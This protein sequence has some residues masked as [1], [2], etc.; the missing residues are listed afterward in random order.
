MVKVF[1]TGVTDAAAC[2]QCGVVAELRPYGKDNALICFE[3]GMKDE[4]T[5]R[6]KFLERMTDSSVDAE[7]LFK[8]ERH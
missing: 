8:G 6:A 4:T 3:C 1:L 5:T 7:D 2:S